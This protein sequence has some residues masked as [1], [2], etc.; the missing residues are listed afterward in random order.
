M[1]ITAPAQL[2]ETDGRV[3][4]LVSLLQFYCTYDHCGPTVENVRLR[5]FSRVLRLY[6]GVCPSVGPLVRWSVGP[7]VRWSVGLLV[8]WSKT[9]SLKRS[10]NS[11]FWGFLRIAAPD[12][13]YATDSR[14]SDLVS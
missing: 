7:L 13:L 9:L 3:S 11:I 14:A 12:Q 5:I 6:K 10:K 4:G 1:S 2:Y 8:R